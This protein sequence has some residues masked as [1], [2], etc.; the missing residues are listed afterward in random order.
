M[1]KKLLIVA[2]VYTMAAA[3]QALAGQSEAES[4]TANR[5]QTA[6]PGGFE[7]G[8]DAFD[9]NYREDLDGTDF[10][11]D[12]GK[13]FG[14][15]AAYVETLGSGWFLRAEA[16][17][18]FGSVDYSS[19]D[20][21]IKGVDQDVTQVEFHI[22]RDFLLG[23]VTTVTPFTGI[24]G[25]VLE[26]HG[27]GEET[28]SGFAAYDRRVGYT[29][30]P[31]GLAAAFPFMGR[32]TLVFTGQ[33]NIVVRGEAKSKFSEIDEEFPDLKLKLD[34][35]SGFEAGAMVRMPVG[36]NTLAFG[37]FVRH[38]K[39]EQS[40]SQIFEEEGDQI[41]FFEPRN[42]TTEFGLRLTFGF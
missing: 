33:Y 35:G 15:N 7:L 3:P 23:G 30:I 22:G 8:I 32:S 31:I 24:G 14:L 19:S 36:R 20:G 37:P 38:W 28:E 1:Q 27:G 29:Y 16:T 39:I 12:D 6:T 17:S 21:D 18:A 25:R 13:F 9:Y 41:E 2:A 40:K 10:V 42:S 5:A 26:D 11:R 34:G 4:Q